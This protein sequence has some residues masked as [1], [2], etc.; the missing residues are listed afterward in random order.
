MKKAA[1]RSEKVSVY[2]FN[3]KSD[4]WWRQHAN[5]IARLPV[6]VFQFPWA[7]IQM[8]AGSVQRSNEFSITVAESTLFVSGRD[9]D[10]EIACSQLSA[11]A[12][13]R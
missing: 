11:T 1:R 4:T 7:S 13:N 10:V 12:D 5:E 6:A 2:S 9:L 3:S 8:L